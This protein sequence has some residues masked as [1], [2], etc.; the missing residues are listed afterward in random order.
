LARSRLRLHA[1]VVG[2]GL[3]LSGCAKNAPQDFLEPEGEIANDVDRL[4]NL[5]FPIAVFFFFL[6]MLL[7]VV[8]MVRFRSRGDDD[9]P[10]QIH[11]NTAL[12]IGWTIV[13]AL[14]LLFVGILTVATLFDITERPTGRNV[15]NVTV[16]GHQWWWEYEYPDH[17]VTT[18]NELHIPVGTKVDLELKSADVIHSFWPPKLAGKV[19]VSPGRVHRMT[20]VADEPNK[21]YLGQCAEF[22][23]VS[24]ANMRLRVY[25]H[26]KEG[27]D[28]WVAEQARQPAVPGGGSA[29][30]GALLFRAKGCGGCHTVGGYTAG[31]IGPDLSHFSSRDT[32]AG[33]IFE[34]TD[35]NLRRWLRD[36]PGEK[37]MMPDNGLGMPNLGL[38]EAEITDL[39]AY[40]RT[41]K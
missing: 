34:N 33:S 22:C 15:L 30:N 9:A 37:P 8:A 12:E 11:G 41:L 13:P 40:L 24:H 32:F 38:T 14:I 27:F 36:P 25:T 16:T 23:G 29:G 3:L 4:W 19:D 5:V 39:M 6:V 1:L 20:I 35:A 2:L 31:D 28:R 10:R 17:K 7:L 26:T 21:T 18:A